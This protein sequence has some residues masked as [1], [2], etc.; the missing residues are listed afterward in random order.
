MRAVDTLPNF[1]LAF[2]PLIKDSV[3][4]LK[5]IGKISWSHVASQNHHSGVQLNVDDREWCDDFDDDALISMQTDEQLSSQ[6]D[7]G[8]RAQDSYV[9][10]YAK[11]RRTFHK[12]VLQCRPEASL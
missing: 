12:I 8:E 11:V 9:R 10:L 1:T 2:P 3:A 4:I 7:G 6:C 5:H